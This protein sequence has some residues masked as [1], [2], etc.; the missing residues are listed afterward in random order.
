MHSCRKSS[1]RQR[2]SSSLASLRLTAPGMCAHRPSD[3]SEIALKRNA[4]LWSKLNS[5]RYCLY[6]TWSTNWSRTAPLRRV[7]TAGWLAL[8]VHLSRRCATCYRSR[9]ETMC[10]GMNDAGTMAI[11]HHTPGHVLHFSYLSF[12]G[13]ILQM[14][15]LRVENWA[16]VMQFTVYLFAAAVFT[17]NAHPP[18]SVLVGRG[19][20]LPERSVWRCCA[21][22]QRPLQSRHWTLVC[23]RSRRGIALL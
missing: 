21:G 14:L 3:T 11:C 23:S 22:S 9:F 10:F 16:I 20:P 2:T 18:L 5:T 12:S 15:L 17:L 19:H 8:L 6:K 4:S 13:A 7:A 1:W